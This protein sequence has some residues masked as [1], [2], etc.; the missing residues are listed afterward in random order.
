[1]AGNF[2]VLSCKAGF[3]VLSM[4]VELSSRVFQAKWCRADCPII[5]LSWLRC[6][7]PSDNAVM[8]L[9]DPAAQR[10]SA[11]IYFQT[12]LGS[13]CN[14]C[15]TNATL[16][17]IRL[18]PHGAS[19][20]PGVWLK[21]LPLLLLLPLSPHLWQVPPLQK[22]HLITIRPHQCSQDITHFTIFHHRNPSQHNWPHA[23][24][25][26]CVWAKPLLCVWAVVVCAFVRVWAPYLLSL[27]QPLPL[28]CH[29]VWI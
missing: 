20:L 26:V 29:P 1:M 3:H 18:G 17:Q 27:A 9:V 22:M 6:Q 2:L 21:I 11:I 15:K 4:V 8:A 25:A 24:P 7:K 23:I 12:L 28:L 10:I 5:G 13:S 14:N 19:D 16:S